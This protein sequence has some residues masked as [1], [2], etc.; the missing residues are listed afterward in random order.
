MVRGKEVERKGPGTWCSKKLLS[1]YFLNRSSKE[2]L[3]SCQ[4]T[5][6][7]NWSGEPASRTTGFSEVRLTSMTYRQAY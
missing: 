2:V 6:K 3:V 4:F 1:R 7:V 5:E